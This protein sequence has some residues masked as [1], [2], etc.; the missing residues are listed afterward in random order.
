MKEINYFDTPYSRRKGG[1]GMADFM[2]GVLNDRAK[3]RE[4]IVQTLKNTKNKFIPLQ[5]LTI[6]TNEKHS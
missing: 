6:K 1:A 4:H 2:K 5:E 3:D